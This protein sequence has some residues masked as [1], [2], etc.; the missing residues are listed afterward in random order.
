MA[1]TNVTPIRAAS[2]LSNSTQPPDPS[3]GLD[4]ALNRMSVFRAALTC[5]NEVTNQEATT[6]TAVRAAMLLARCVQ[7]F[8]GLYNDLDR[9]I[10]EAKGKAHA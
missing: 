9:A 10:I 4:E 1:K 8:D 5:A 2:G 6:E 7:E 3:E